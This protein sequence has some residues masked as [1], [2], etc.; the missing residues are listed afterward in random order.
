MTSDIAPYLSAEPI[1]AKGTI[2]ALQEAAMRTNSLFSGQK[3]L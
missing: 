1:A 3:V 2:M